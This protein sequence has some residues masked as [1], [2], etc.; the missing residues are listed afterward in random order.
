MKAIIAAA[1]YWTRMLPITKSIPKEMLPVWTK[2]V[3]HYIVEALSNSWI[4]DILMIT[5]AGKEALENYFDKNYELEETLRK[6]WKYDK[7]EE[8]D[9]IKNMANICFTRQK[10]QLG[11]AHA[12]L[13]AKEWV[14]ED[15][16]F[17]T[18][19]DT[20]FEEKIFKD[21]LEIHLKTH[22]PVIALKEIPW[23]EV[24]KYWVVEIK[25]NKIISL[26]E[27]PSKEEA[28]SNLI[29]VWAYILP[30][31]IF[32]V[33]ENLPINEKTGEILLT[34]ALSEIMKED[35]IIPYI[36]DGKVYDTWNPQAWLKANLEIW[37]QKS[38]FEVWRV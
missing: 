38:W 18:V 20:I 17:L 13:S 4:K 30:K 14:K 26:I 25:N 36:C 11:F 9:K 10:E 27:K 15:Y 16:F 3:I 12:V 37:G 1:W 22:K 2:P 7:L 19:G 28:P 5:S 32:E 8:L 23:N 6:K 29:I 31:K 35:E 24:E 21:M 33:I 34:E